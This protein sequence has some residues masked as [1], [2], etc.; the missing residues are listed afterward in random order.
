MRKDSPVA[1]YPLA[2]W[3]EAR[4]RPLKGVIPT[5]VSESA[6]AD[7]RPSGGTLRLVLFG[8]FLPCFWF[9]PTAKSQRPTVR[10]SQ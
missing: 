6:T 7:E 5:E 3:K 2:A 9:K 10:L 8:L 4:N 1:V